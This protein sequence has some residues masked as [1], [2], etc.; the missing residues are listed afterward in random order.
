V[1]RL[2]PQ[3]LALKRPFFHPGEL[4]WKKILLD[5]GQWKVINYSLLLL[6]SWHKGR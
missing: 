3:L 5:R 4:I 1:N 2:C 6:G